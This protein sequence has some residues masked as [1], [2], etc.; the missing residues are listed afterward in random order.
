MENCWLFFLQNK[1]LTFKLALLLFHS[2]NNLYQG[3]SH[4]FPIDMC[5]RAILFYPDVSQLPRLS[6]KGLQY[7]T[8]CSQIRLLGNI[9]L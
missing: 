3:V 1:L 5:S 4:I 9:K 6:M 7:T 2:I 8:V